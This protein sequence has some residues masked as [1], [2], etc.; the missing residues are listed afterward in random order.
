M[1]EL[2]N[3]EIVLEELRRTFDKIYAAGDALDAKLNN[4]LNF[5]SL[6]VSFA[7]TIQISTLESKVGITFWALLGIVLLL[8]LVHF[9]C[10]KNG[11]HPRLYP[12]P[13]SGDRDTIIEK[14]FKPSEGQTLNQVIGNYL[15]A[16]EVVK[17]FNDQKARAIVVANY[18]LVA[19][20][21]AL[22][23]AVPLGLLCPTPTICDVL[24]T[25]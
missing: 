12:F 2:T 4:L 3:K 1:A 17:T 22:L 11:L 19:I 23:L 6:I 7:A 10:I 18:L 5:S 8:Y 13:M 20:V 21:I 15:G 24:H 14:Y 25:K 9:F 16:I